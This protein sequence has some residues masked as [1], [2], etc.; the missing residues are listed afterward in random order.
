VLNAYPM[1]M[2]PKQ[3]SSIYHILKGS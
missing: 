2:Q 3:G 1:L